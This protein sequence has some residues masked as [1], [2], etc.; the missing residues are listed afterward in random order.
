M[1]GPHLFIL[2]TEDRADKVKNTIFHAYAD[3]T[4]LYLYCHCDHTTAVVHDSNAASWKWVTGWLL[5]SSGWTP[6]R[7]LLWTWPGSRYGFALAADWHR[8][9]QR[10]YSL[11]WCDNR[12]SPRIWA[13]RSTYPLSVRRVAILLLAGVR[14]SLDIDSAK[15][16]VHA[17]GWL[18]QLGAG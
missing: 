17:S 16:L 5:I 18:V 2:Y 14:Y 12:Q 6:T 1:L 4:Q 3:D 13:F 9:C 15:T 11:A 7:Q 10:S 8:R